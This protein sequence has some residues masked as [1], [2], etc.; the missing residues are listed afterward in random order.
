MQN[1]WSVLPV[2]SPGISPWLLLVARG[3]LVR[4]AWRGDRSRLFLK[5]HNKGQQFP[6]HGIEIAAS[7]TA[8][9]NNR[10]LGVA[11]NG[12]VQWYPQHHPATI[13]IKS[14][15]KTS[16]AQLSR[17]AQQVRQFVHELTPGLWSWS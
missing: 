9:G 8:A 6:T 1:C 10:C 4:G 13:T 15:K 11:G 12:I 16:A 2:W 14:G 17:S 7:G 3:A 5:T